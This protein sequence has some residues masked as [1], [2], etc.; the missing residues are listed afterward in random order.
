[1]IISCWNVVLCRRSCFFKVE[2]MTYT[3]LSGILS[4]MKAEFLR[5]IREN[6]TKLCGKEDLRGV[7]TVS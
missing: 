5:T 7:Y 1:M 2:E 3:G 4:D 6:Q